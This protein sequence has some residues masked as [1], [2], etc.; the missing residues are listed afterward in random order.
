MFRNKIS[1]GSSIPSVQEVLTLVTKATKAHWKNIAQNC[2]QGHALY[3]PW[4]APPPG[5]IKINTDAAFLDGDASTGVIFRD[6]KGSILYAVTSTH[7]CLDAFSAEALA[8]LKACTAADSLKT[9]KVIFESDCLNIIT[10]LNTSFGSCNWNASPILDKI[11]KIWT[12]WPH[13]NFKFASRSSNGASHALAS[14]AKSCSFDGIV[15][16]ID[17]PISVFCDRGSPLVNSSFFSFN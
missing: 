2:Q 13:W 11:R 12:G 17:I 4:T 5:W 8:L 10:C 6:H 9:K 14:W 1:H 16:L 15:P 7:S 3:Q